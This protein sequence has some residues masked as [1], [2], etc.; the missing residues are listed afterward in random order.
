MKP[1]RGTQ[2]GGEDYERGLVLEDWGRSLL[3]YWTLH[4]PPKRFP[5][6]HTASSLAILSATA[7]SEI[8][9]WIRSSVDA[10]P[11]KTLNRHYHPARALG[12]R[13]A[14]DTMFRSFKRR[15]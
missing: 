1:V 8:H 6:A 9:P 2:T 11:R 12:T 13:V 14:K 4:Y 15:T 7:R 5:L 10:D 3:H